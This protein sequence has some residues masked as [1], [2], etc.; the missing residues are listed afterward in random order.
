MVQLLRF[1]PAPMLA[2]GLVVGLPAAT[3]TTSSAAV[4]ATE[5]PGTVAPVVSTKHTAR[6]VRRTATKP[7]AASTPTRPT[8]PVRAVVGAS[9]TSTPVDRPAAVR[10]TASTTPTKTVT[11]VEAVKQGVVIE[12]G[13]QVHGIIGNVPTTTPTTTALSPVDTTVV[14]VSENP[15]NTVT[16]VVTQTVPEVAPET[17]PVA[18]VAVSETADASA[19]TD[20]GI[21]TPEEPTATE[22]GNAGDPPPPGEEPAPWGPGTPDWDLRITV[23]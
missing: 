2:L 9:Q 8:A 21:V 14:P 19:V 17:A 15:E 3:P 7:S 22:A 12:P 10:H 5:T 6:P 1:L 13:L 20:E 18:V 23:A 4:A 11:H 16:P